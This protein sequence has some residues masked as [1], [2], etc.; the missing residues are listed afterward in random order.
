[1]TLEPGVRCVLIETHDRAPSACGHALVQN[2]HTH[3]HLAEGAQLQHLRLALPQ[4]QDRMAQHVHARLAQGARY[5]QALVATGA[6]YHL[7]R[8]VVQLQ[9][10]NAQARTAALLLPAGQV[11]GSKSHPAGCGPH[12]RPHRGTGPGRR[13]RA[14]GGQRPQ[15]H[16]PRRP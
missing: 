12:R 6:A 1:M 10:A 16:C 3:I 8:T 14:R 4:A 9:G 11:L 7:Q 13:P 5:Q 2:L 15:P